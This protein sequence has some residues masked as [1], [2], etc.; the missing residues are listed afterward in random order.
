MFFSSSHSHDPQTMEDFYRPSLIGRGGPIAPTTAPGTDF[1]LKNHMVRLLRQNCQFHGFRDED[2]NEHLNKYLSITQFLKQNGVSQDSIS[3]NLF[4][5]SLTHEAES[6]FYHLKTHSIHTWEEMI[7]KFLS[8]Y[9]P[10]S[11]ALQLR[12]DILNFRQLPMESVY[13]AWERFKSCL[14]KCPNHRI[15]LLNQIMTFYHGITMIDQDKIMVAAG[16]NIMR[17]TP[18]EAYDLIENMTQHHFQWDAEVYYDTTTGV[19]AHY[20]ETTS[21]L[22]AQIKV[23]G[24]QT[25]YTIQSVQHQPGPGHPNTVYY[26]DDSDKSDENEPSEVLDI[27]KLIH[28]LCGNPTPSS[29]SVVESLSPSPIPCGDSDSLVEETD[30]LLSHSDDSVPDYETFCFDIK[31]KSGGSTTSHSNHSLLEYESFCFDVDHIEEKS[32]GS[33]TSHSNHSLPE[34]ESFC[35]DVDH[36]EEKSSGSTTSHYELSLPSLPE[37]ESFHFD[38]SIDSLSPVDRSDSH[39]EEFA[40]ELAHIT[41]PPEYDCFYFDLEIVPGDFTRLLKE[42]IFDL[43]TKGLTINELNDSSLLLSYCD[44]SLSKEFSE[45]DLLVSFPSGNKDKIFVPG[46]FIFKR[47]QY[48]RFHIFPLDG[49]PTISFVSDSLLLTD[50][51]EIETFLSFP[52]GN[53]DKVFDPEIFFINKVLSFTRKT[54][55]LLSDNFMIDKCHILSKIYLKIVS[56]ISFHPKDKEIQGESS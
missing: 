24:K 37:Y 3:L 44:S 21:V 34:Y 19:S 5:F 54:P 13:E 6:W 39:H 33:T 51:P 4:P 32:N 30:T 1:V 42:N 15:L 46:I 2:A 8:K 53:E 56:S 36:I 50:P 12:K 23:L 45:I 52:A 55:D 43:S 25:A 40:D 27:Q 38:I 29:D 35:F 7:L 22:S 20:S 9:Y 49:F 17:K 10:Y 28:S 48:K 18:Q 16:G 41:S 14:R 26:S 31:E 47:V 11:R